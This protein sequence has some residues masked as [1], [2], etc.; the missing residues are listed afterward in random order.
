VPMIILH[1]RF[2]GND[3]KPPGITSVNVN[4]GSSVL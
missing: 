2:H 3:I 1:S 4:N